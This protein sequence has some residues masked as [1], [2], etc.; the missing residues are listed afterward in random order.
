L[1]QL[2]RDNLQSAHQK[3]VPLRGGLDPIKEVVESR[4]A[5]PQRDTGY[6]HK[7]PRNYGYR[8]RN[9]PKG[10]VPT[11]NKENVN[12]P[13]INQ[14]SRVLQQRGAAIIG[15]ERKYAIDKPHISHIYVPG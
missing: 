9:E 6:K 2:G 11:Y 12:L 1:D 10:Y 13:K 5:D 4:S 7:D 3:P 14:P 8:M 15:G